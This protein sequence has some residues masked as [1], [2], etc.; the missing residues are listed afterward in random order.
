MN[1]IRI[2]TLVPLFLAASFVAAPAR[3]HGGMYRG[4][5]PTPAV[6]P[7]NSPG[8]P[9]VTSGPIAGA[10]PHGW[11]FWWEYNK[12][13]YLNLR[14]TVLGSV[15]PNAG[16]GTST[17]P[18]PLRPTAAEIED[19]VLP[20]IDRLMR[21]HDHPDVATAGMIAMAKIGRLHPEIDVPARLRGNLQSGNQEVRET[22]ALA[23]GIFGRPEVL[24]DLIALAQDERHGRQLTGRSRVDERTRAFALYGLGLFARRS[25]DAAVKQQALDVAA[26]ILGARELVDRDVGVAALQAI[27]VIAPS[28]TESA[29]KRLGWQ[30]LR[31]LDEFWERDVG[32]GDE[33]VQAHVPTAVARLLGRGDGDDHRRHLASWIEELESRDRADGV[34]QSIVLAIGE[35]A[36]PPESGELAAAASATL[37]EYYRRGKD[38][39]A[40]Y[41][42]LIAL[43]R[44]GGEQNRIDLMKE[45][46]RARKATERPWVALALG[47]LAR[48]RSDATGTVDVT[49]GRVLQSQLSAVAN[50]EFRAACAIALGL[51]GYQ[52]AAGELKRLLEKHERQDPI[53]GYLC[54]ALALLPD[55]SARA[56][57]RRVLHESALR[58]AV[59]TH[60][61]MAIAL[62]GRGDAG[63]ELLELW[64]SGES[65]LAR[66]AGIA[67]AF[68]LVGDRRAIEPLVR[69][70]FA[71]D[72]TTT[73]R[74]FVAAALGGVCDK[75]LLPWNEPFA[76]GC[77]YAAVVTTLTNGTTGVL[78]IL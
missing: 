1:A 29:H 64:E 22:A 65:N 35:I 19:V 43:G 63:Q 10:N 57:I 78:D 13:R 41:F 2:G 44:I 6:P 12:D 56:D 74:A 39:Q 36:P 52:A 8:M 4:P 9:T 3:A 67:T 72:T 49:I 53:A 27:G 42:A 30:A 5:S 24:G 55:P 25:A 62:L 51:C 47:V 33:I 71:R 50:D 37:W 23:L 68:R 69:M 54:L 45:L 48:E 28:W 32:R 60:G 17:G 61:A 16:Q 7:G 76:A 70:M 26:G 18:A 75:D 38:Q 77:N 40:R 31:T 66:L 20:A 58:P 15:D 59:V 73:S 21:Q 11:Q 34:H 14:E 46:P